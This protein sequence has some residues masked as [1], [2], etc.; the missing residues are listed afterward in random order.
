MSDIAPILH[1]RSRIAV[2]GAGVSG[3]GAAYALKDVH[4]VTVF[5]KEDRLGGHANTVRIDYDGRKIDVDTGFIVFNRLNYPN[6]TALFEHLDIATYRSDM[7]FGFS[8]DGDVEWSSNGVS[9]LFAQKRNLFRPSFVS[10]LGEILRFNGRAIADLESGHL[11][12]LTLGQYLDREGYGT[13][14]RTNYLLPMGAAIWSSTEAEMARYPAEAFVRFFKNHRLVNAVRPKW[15]TVKG[16]SQVYVQRIAD[17]L[18]AAGVRFAP[19]ARRVTRLDDGVLVSHGAG[20]AERFDEVILACHSDQALRLLSDADADEREMLGA[21]PYAP[22]TAVLHRDTSFLPK[23]SGA[24][25]AWCYTRHDDAAAAAV[26]YDMNRLQGIDA[27]TPLLV[28]LNPSRE[29]DPAL[30]FGRFEYDHPQFSAAGLAAQRIFNRIQ[31]VRRTWFAGAWL[32]YGFHEDGLRS[33]LR[34]ALR[35]GGR[36]PWTFAE[37]DVDGGRWGERPR[38][39]RTAAVAAAE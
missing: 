9:G 19:A 13:R 15:E 18:E 36:I 12:G 21:I 39:G 8:L 7:S 38:D 25:A 28:T 37:G 3:L 29:P 17:E 6:L 35:L 16:G 26:T 23:R 27:K 5:E 10:M 34:A 11:A 2:I 24:R 4:E 32:G 31:G 22:N 33:G 30:V 1:H 20:Y 14:F